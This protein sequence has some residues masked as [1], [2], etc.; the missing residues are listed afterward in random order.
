MGALLVAERTKKSISKAIWYFEEALQ[1]DRPRFKAFVHAGLAHCYAQQYHRLAQRSPEIREKAREQAN[2][3][4]SIWE[5]TREKPEPWIQ[6]T[7]AMTMVIDEGE[8]AST[9][10]ELKNMFIPAINLFQI[11]V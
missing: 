1:T 6:Y 9:L 11:T 10:K 2:I 3:A 7:L 8:F 5:K 4:E